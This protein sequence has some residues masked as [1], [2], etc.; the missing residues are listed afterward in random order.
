MSQLEERL[1]DQVRE[2]I[3]ARIAAA[4][5]WSLVRAVPIVVHQIRRRKP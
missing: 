1:T 5:F 3:P 4:I 2:S